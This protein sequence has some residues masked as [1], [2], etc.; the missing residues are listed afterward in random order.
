MAGSSREIS[1]GRSSGTVFQTTSR[2]MSKYAWTSRLRIPTI[3]S[4]GIFGKFPPV[5]LVTCVDASPTISTSLT[6]A[7]TSWRSLSRSPR[8]P[9]SEGH[10][11]SRGIQHVQQTDFVILAHTGLPPC[12]GPPAG[13][14]GSGPPVFA[15]PP[16]GRRTDATTQSPCRPRPAGRVRYLA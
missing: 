6:S 7:R 12:R 4:H 15:G 16:C 8:P 9:P 3:R 1:S 11:F 10:R 2:L 14:T 5:G 13:S